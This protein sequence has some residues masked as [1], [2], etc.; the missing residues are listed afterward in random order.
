[1]N[2]ALDLI[3]DK[4]TKGRVRDS[5]EKLLKQKEDLLEIRELVMAKK[6]TPEHYGLYIK[7]PAG[8]EG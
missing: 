2:N 6:I 4:D 5:K 1:V 3:G 7:Y 8:Y